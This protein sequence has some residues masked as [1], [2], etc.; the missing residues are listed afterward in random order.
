MMKKMSLIALCGVQLFSAGCA[1]VAMQRDIADGHY[2]LE[3]LT[4]ETLQYNEYLTRG[5]YKTYR[6]ERVAGGVKELPAGTDQF[7]VEASVS[8]PGIPGVR[9]AYVQLTGEFKPQKRYM[10]N[11]ERKGNEVKIWAE[12]SATK[13]VVSNVAIAQYQPQAPIENNRRRSICGED[14]QN[15]PASQKVTAK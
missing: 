4:A 12:D 1:S 11:R 7:W 8:K 10:L 14:Q 2:V 9:Y 3:G 6:G 15:L 13:E 5:C